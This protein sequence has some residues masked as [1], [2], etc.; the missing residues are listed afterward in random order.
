[1]GA[2]PVLAATSDTRIKGPIGFVAGGTAAGIKPSGN[3]DLGLILSDRPAV[4]AAVTTSNLFFAAP[5]ALCRE[6]LARQARI[7][8]VVVNAGCANACTGRRGSSDAK[9]MTILAEQ[10]CGVQIG[11]FLVASTGV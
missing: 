9:K 5:V 8:G 6:R 2:E 10:A 1:M 3:P 7:R 11:D 4:A